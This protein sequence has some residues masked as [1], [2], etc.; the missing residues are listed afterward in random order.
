MAGRADGRTGQESKLPKRTWNDDITE[1]SQRSFAP[2]EL[3]APQQLRSGVFKLAE[4][5]SCADDHAASVRAD[6]TQS[7]PRERSGCRPDTFKRVP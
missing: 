2:D 4:T 1:R 7:F 3:V 5:V 6:G